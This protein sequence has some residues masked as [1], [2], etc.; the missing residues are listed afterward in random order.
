M[1]YQVV[2]VVLKSTSRRRAMTALSA[3]ASLTEDD[4]NTERL[5]TQR[6]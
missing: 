1:L 4:G 3:Q 6:G 2:T 5:R